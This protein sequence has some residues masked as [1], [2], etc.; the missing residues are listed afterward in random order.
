MA[1]RHL[2]GRRSALAGSVTPVAGNSERVLN[3]A[4][5]AALDRRHPRWSAQTGRASDVVI[6]WKGR[7]TNVPVVLETEYAPAES[8]DARAAARLGEILAGSGHTV[9]QAVTVSAPADLAA[10]PAEDLPAAVE[11]AVYGYRQAHLGSEGRVVWYPEKGRL[12]G[13]V[14]DLAGF[15]EMV[16]VNEHLLDEAAEVFEHAVNAAANRLR[17]GGPSPEMSAASDAIAGVLRQQD[18]LQTTRMAVAVI[19]YAFMFQAAIAGMKR[20]GW[21]VPLP[22]PL[23]GKAETLRVWDR[24][25]EVDCWPVFEIARSLL[26]HVPEAEAGEL[27]AGLTAGLAGLM[28]NPAGVEAPRGRRGP[29]PGG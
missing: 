23:D 29:K 12:R 19:A 3:S 21:A 13:T 26:T 1:A 11:R 17:G 27:V 24:I 6:A 8:A 14:D 2:G 15:C 18:S 5:A 25:M 28:P 9:E 4:L 22:S 16:A 10:V 20:G 7:T